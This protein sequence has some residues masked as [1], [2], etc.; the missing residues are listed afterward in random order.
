MTARE[1]WKWQREGWKDRRERMKRCKERRKTAPSS[2]RA[3]LTRK[4]G[5][6]STDGFGFS[7]AGNSARGFGK[8]AEIPAWVAGRILAARRREGRITR[9]QEKE[10]AEAWMT[11]KQQDDKWAKL[12]NVWG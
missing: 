11:L 12:W 7:P 9:A 8:R 10:R 6:D 4:P 3:R 1:A 2:T 5:D